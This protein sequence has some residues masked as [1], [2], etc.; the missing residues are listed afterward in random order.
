VVARVDL[1]AAQCLVRF[2]LDQSL[3]GQHRLKM[4]A[5]DSQIAHLPKVAA[6]LDMEF[7]L[8]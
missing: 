2:C 6:M 8:R 4:V 3:V 5:A 7:L 1:A